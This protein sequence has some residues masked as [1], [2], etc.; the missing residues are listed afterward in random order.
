MPKNKVLTQRGESYTPDKPFKPFSRQTGRHCG[1][2]RLYMQSKM[3]FVHRTIIKIA[4][5]KGARKK[6]SNSKDEKFISL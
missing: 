3:I 2:Q 4:W 6:G 5:K 1:L